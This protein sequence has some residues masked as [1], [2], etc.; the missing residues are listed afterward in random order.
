MRTNKR[1]CAIQFS[2][3]LSDIQAIIQLVG[4]TGTPCHHDVILT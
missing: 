3:L 1:S 2:R 4:Y